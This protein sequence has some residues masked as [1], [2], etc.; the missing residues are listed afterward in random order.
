MTPGDDRPA[1]PRV[2]IVGAGFAGLGCARE[3]AGT[4]VDITLI[5]RNNYHQFLPLLYQVATAQLASDDVGTPLRNLF[6]KEDNIDVVQAE[7]VGVDPETRTVTTADGASYTGDYLVLATGARANFY[8]TPGADEHTLP[9]YSLADAERLRARIIEVFDA[10]DRDPR[11]IDQGAL[12]FVVVG[13]GATGVETAG[14]IA[15]FVNRVAPEAYHDL[16]VHEARIHLVDHGNALLAPFS[17]KAHAYA[18]KVLQRDGVR[19]HLGTGVR[20]ITPSAVH[21]E[22]GSTLPSRCVIWAGGVQAGDLASRIALPRGR[23]GR[24]LAG[25]DLSVD[26]YP[27][28]FVLGDVAGVESPDGGLYPQLGSVA[29]QQGQWTA[30]TIRSDLAGQ[31]RTAFH[32]HDKGIMAMIGRGAAVAEM[33]AKHHELHGAIAFSSWLGVH[34]WLMSGVRTRVDAFISW[35]WDYFSGN[36]SPGLIDHST[37]PTV[38]WSQPAEVPTPRSPSQPTVPAR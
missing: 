12:T 17:D 15:D 11:L 13:G 14:G 38:D 26:G 34:A 30:K 28:V 36:R 24:V 25:H 19:L 16:P 9:L 2:V 21:L 27:N 22:G 8:R 33:G 18:A 37:P 23:G 5:D 10:A 7:V 3:L 20:E 32:Y 31:P 29:L 6:R 4:D 1:R 35:G